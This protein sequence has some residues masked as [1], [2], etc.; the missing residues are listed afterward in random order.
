MA[1]GLAGLAIVEIIS[2]PCPA[3][4]AVLMM[5]TNVEPDRRIEST[6]LV[7]AKP[8][9]LVV[10]SF[11]RLRVREISIGNTPIGDGSRDAMHELTH[12]S[13]PAALMRIRPVGDVA[14][15]IF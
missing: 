11:R 1:F 10:K 8:G 15:E 9:Q 5:Q 14:I 4:D 12:R 6:M 13:F 7:Q 2:E 3:A